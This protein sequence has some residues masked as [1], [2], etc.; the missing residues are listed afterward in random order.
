MKK[1]FCAVLAIAAMA[2][3]SNEY[4][5]DTQKQAIAFGETF[6][7]NSTRAATDNTYLDGKDVEAFKVWGTVKGTHDGAQDVAIFSGAEV[8]R[9]NGLTGYNETKA[10]VCNEV[11]YW[12]PN[13][14]YNF[15][16][17]VDGEFNPETSEIAYTVSTQK[18]LLLATATASV[19]DDGD[20]TGTNE[21]GL[22]AFTFDHLL[23]KAY[24]TFQTDGAYKT[25][26][27]TYEI[28]DIQF[29]NA[30]TSGT[31]TVGAT[32]PWEGTGSDDLSFGDAVTL[33]PSKTAAVSTTSELVKVFIPQ[34]SV[35]IS[36]TVT[37]KYNGTEI[38]KKN[39][40]FTVFN[41][42]GKESKA[43]H[44]YNFVAEFTE[45]AQIQFTVKD[46]TDWVEEDDITLE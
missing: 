6:V 8:T 29:D 21:D 32:T 17:V 44:S 23:S 22:V 20:I 18:D 26:D 42:E 19:D 11:Q 36:F 30:Y 3:C 39:Y 1:I 37:I 28:S 7:N 10:W 41:G 27:Y 33:D 24:F 34:A 5:I 15:T 38:S 9:P 40:G 2:S 25:A 43:G 13:A 31:Y 16:A 46:V 35:K 12:V 45:N 4:T 14:N